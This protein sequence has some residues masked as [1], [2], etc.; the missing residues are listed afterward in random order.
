MRLRLSTVAAGIVCSVLAVPVT[1]HHAIED[2]YDLT[3][4]VT[5]TGT[6][7]RVEWVN[8]HTQLYLDITR[9]DGTT[10]TWSIELGPPNALRRSGLDFSA[11][12]QGDRV[13][14]DVWPAKD[15]SQSASVRAI[16]LPDGR[17]FSSGPSMWTRQSN[18]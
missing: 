7:S 17:V 14:I 11:L 5:L 13:V 3:R 8:P 18:R 4:T 6:V 1:A 12:K 15:G 10:L 9:G 2:Q 16:T